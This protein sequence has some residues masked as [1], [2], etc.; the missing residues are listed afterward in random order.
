[1]ITL[2]TPTG[3]IVLIFV[4]MLE[5]MPYHLLFT[6]EYIVFIL[7]LFIATENASSHLESPRHILSEDESAY[8]CQNEEMLL[9]ISA[10]SLRSSKTFR[11][12]AVCTLSCKV[13]NF[14]KAWNCN[15]I[16]KHLFV[17]TAYH[18]KRWIPAKQSW[19]F[20]RCRH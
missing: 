2:F 12:I 19:N 1:M 8:F 5:E 4:T 20:L 3:Y 18:K 14:N 10:P 16:I 17:C 11:N 7:F 9:T 13:N 6:S 15:G